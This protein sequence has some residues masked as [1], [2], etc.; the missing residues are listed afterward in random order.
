MET[1]RHS[2]AIKD[3]NEAIRL[4]RTPQQGSTITPEEII[5]L[6]DH[7]YT[8]VRGICYFK[9]QRLEPAVADFS[10]C[11]E[12]YDGEAKDYYL[13]WAAR[14][15]LGEIEQAMEDLDKATGLD[16]KIQELLEREL[17]NQ[18]SPAN[19]SE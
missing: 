9:S 5:G 19:S 18:P 12:K 8:F 14:Q 6:L 17:A 11:I 10:Y 15:G 7:T 16:P 3:L 13:R 1:G 2:A 4:I